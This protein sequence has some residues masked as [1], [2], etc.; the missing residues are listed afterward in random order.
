MLKVYV[1]LL[2][3][4]SR[5]TH[6]VPRDHSVSVTIICTR[7]VGRATPRL[8]TW[9]H[10]RGGRRQLHLSNLRVALYITFRRWLQY[11]LL[12]NYTETQSTYH[13]QCF[14]ALI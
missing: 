1:S 6:M 7:H 14:Q 4:F 13:I 8:S 3:R 10:G 9:G 12:Q 11:V 2:L 5:L